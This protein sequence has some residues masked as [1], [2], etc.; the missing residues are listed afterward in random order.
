[1]TVPSPPSL[2]ERIARCSPGDILRIPA[3]IHRVS[4][5][6]RITG[7]RDLHLIGEDGAVLRGTIPLRRADFTEEAPGVFSA[8]VPARVDGFFVGDRAYTMA[9]YPKA[10]D[11][12]APFGGYAADCL[13]PEK[14]KDWASPAGGYIHA[15]HRHLWGGYSYRIEGKNPDGTLA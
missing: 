5:P 15:M 12:D 3:G 9:R 8:S 1:M 14:T 11:P 4:A 6:L 2:G 10:T 13:F 7:L